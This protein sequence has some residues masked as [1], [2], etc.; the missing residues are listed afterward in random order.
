M[1]EPKLP[2]GLRL[3][4]VGPLPQNG[5]FA[6]LV[7]EYRERADDLTLSQIALALAAYAANLAQGNRP[8]E[9][10]LAHIV[11][12]AQRAGMPLDGAAVRAAWA[13][14]GGGGYPGA[15]GES[16]AS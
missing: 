16:R 3:V 10:E 9:F 2:D 11:A 6:G 1:T 4:G 5:G 15:F 8:L 13:S 12:L 14:R 7:A